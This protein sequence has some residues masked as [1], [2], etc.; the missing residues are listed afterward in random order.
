MLLL[1]PRRLEMKEDVKF[2]EGVDDELGGARATNEES[3]LYAGV[4][5]SNGLSFSFG[6][7]GEE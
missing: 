1:E 5:G 3:M 6:S 2:N 4:E 7:D